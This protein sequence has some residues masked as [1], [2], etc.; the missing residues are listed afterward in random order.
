MNENNFKYLDDQ[1]FYKNFGRGHSE[2]LKEKMKEGKADFTLIH[3]QDFGKDATVATLHFRK[4]SESDMYFFNSY[5]L[6]LKVAGQKGP[7][8]QTFYIN[9]DPKKREHEDITLKEGYNLLSGRAVNKN[10]VSKEGATY[11]AWVQLDFKVADTRGNYE[12]KKF[13][14][15]YGFDLEKSLGK[16]PIKELGE[17]KSREYLSDSLKRGNRQS[18]TLQ[19]GGV[20]QKIFV[21]AAP[22]Y[23]GLNFYDNNMKRLNMQTLYESKGEG[24]SEKKAEG[25]QEGKSAAVKQDAGDD[26]GGGGNRSQNTSKRKSR[27][28]GIA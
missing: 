23:K 6:S 2:K 8:K 22:Q 20:D 17:E 11:N 15:N 12:E 7:I 14:Q 25:K 5:D 19:H 3:Q 9:N 18:V 4:S 27:G 28:Q 13:H 10:M 1:I 26:E 24:Q 16:H 21:E